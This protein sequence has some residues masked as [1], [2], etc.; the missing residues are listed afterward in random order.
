VIAQTAPLITPQVVTAPSGSSISVGVANTDT[1]TVTGTKA[2]G[3]P[4][5]SVQFYVCGPLTSA[6]SCTS[7]KTPVGGPQPLNASTSKD[8]ATVTSPSFSANA[9][10]TWC[11]A[12]DYS[13]SSFYAV[14]SDTSTGECYTVSPDTVVVCPAKQF[15]SGS[16]TTDS[17]TVNVTGTSSTKATIDLTLEEDS[18]AACGTGWNIPAQYS[19]LT[20]TKF[21]SASPMTITDTVDNTKVSLAG[22]I[23]YNDPTA[24]IDAGGSSVTTGLLPTCAQVSNAPPCIVSVTMSG[25]NA[26]DVFTAPVGDPKFHV[27]PPKTPKPP[28]K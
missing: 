8:T 9:A 15:C 4:D 24:F 19:N 13:G 3:T 7:Q 25:A 20:E 12:G 28:K 10:G 22:A 18:F 14:G 1:A 5:G 17:G 16:Q 27:K 2:G 11:F 6:Q 26:V 21:T 23:C